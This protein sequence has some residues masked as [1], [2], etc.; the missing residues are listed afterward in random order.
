MGCIGFY[1]V[2]LGFLRFSLVSLGFNGF[3]PTYRGFYGFSMG[4]HRFS[5]VFMGFQWLFMGFQWVPPE[6]S[7]AS[8]CSTRCYWVF[9]WFNRISIGFTGFLSF[10]MG[11]YR[12][13]GSP[14]RCFGARNWIGGGSGRISSASNR[15][16]SSVSFLRTG[17]GR[18]LP[19]TGFSFLPSFFFLPT[20]I[21]TCFSIE[22]YRKCRPFR[23]SFYRVF[24]EFLPSFT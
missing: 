22:Q 19:L 6:L 12:L 1:W 17:L 16:F 23:L 11:C 7:C 5:W 3:Y 20:P 9:A 21:R 10:W 13:S 15:N 14:D 8:L 4:F 24:T 18:R 2:L